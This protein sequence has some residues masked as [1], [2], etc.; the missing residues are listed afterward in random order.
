[1]ARAPRG[2]VPPTPA[3]QL[4]QAVQRALDIAKKARKHRQKLNSDNFYANKLAE[5]RVNAVNAFRDLSTQSAGDVSAM[6]EMIEVV[7]SPNADV[8]KKAEVAREL[9]FSLRTTWREHERPVAQTEQGALFPL[10]LLSQTKRGYLIVIGRQM[11]GC[12]GVGWYDGC[13]VMMRRLMEIVLIEAF[14]KKNL[15]EKIKDKNGNYLQL[16]DLI[17]VTLNESS[18]A[19]SRNTKSALPQLRDIGHASAHGRYFTAQ[20][21]DIE[22]I[23]HGCRVVVEEF[24][25]HAGML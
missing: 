21:S 24:L 6:A 3:S 20:K 22:K 11:N 4:E 12:F 10:N 19:L 7:F 18:F 13:A 9:V 5:L 2:K 15:S 14:E 16:T 1:M 8:K 23:R 17:G 25:H